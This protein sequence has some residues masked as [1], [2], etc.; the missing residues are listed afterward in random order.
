MTGRRGGL[1]ND[2]GDKA[3]FSPTQRGVKS[4]TDWGIISFNVVTKYLTLSWGGEGGAKCFGPAISP[5]CS[6]P[7]RN[8]PVPKCVFI[9]K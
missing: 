2:R 3:S 9:R 7:L 1:Q 4:H 8:Y 5:V 6:T